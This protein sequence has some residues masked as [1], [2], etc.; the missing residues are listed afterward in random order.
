MRLLYSKSEVNN[1]RFAIYH[2]YYKEKPGITEST[3]NFFLY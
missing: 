1:N 3:H 2:M